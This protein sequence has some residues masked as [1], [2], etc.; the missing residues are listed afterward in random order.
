MNVPLL[1]TLDDARMTVKSVTGWPGETFEDL[2][3]KKPPDFRRNTMCQ[4]SS[5]MINGPFPAPESL[6]AVLSQARA[7]KFLKIA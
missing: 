6:K 4:I 2:S 1:E 7:S 5:E 3:R